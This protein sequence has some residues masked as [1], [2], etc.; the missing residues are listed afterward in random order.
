MS[1][2]FIVTLRGLFRLR[3]RGH[4]GKIYIE[5]RAFPEFGSN[6]VVERVAL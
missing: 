1:F 3:L 2:I 4:R 6:A 5:C